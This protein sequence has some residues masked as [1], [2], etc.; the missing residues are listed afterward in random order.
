MIQSKCNHEWVK[1]T[2]EVVVHVDEYDEIYYPDVTFSFCRKCSKS[3]SEQDR[4]AEI[5]A[6]I[7]KELEV[8]GGEG[9]EDQYE[10]AYMFAQKL[11][12]RIQEAGDGH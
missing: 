5:L 4:D 6:L 9:M 8:F 10:G 3:K 12:T 1:A 11:K 2:R 7:E